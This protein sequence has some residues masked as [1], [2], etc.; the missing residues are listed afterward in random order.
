M[1]EERK[2]GELAHRDRSEAAAPNLGEE[3]AHPEK[4]DRDM[5]PVCADKGEE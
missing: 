2:A 5:E 1:P 4:S 3:R